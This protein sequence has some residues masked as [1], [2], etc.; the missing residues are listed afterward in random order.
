MNH[1]VSDLL[2][3]ADYQ[4][5]KRRAHVQVEEMMAAAA[6]E[7]RRRGIQIEAA[8][9]ELRRRG[10]QIEDK[11]QHI[12]ELQD[13]I[14]AL[15]KEACDMRQSLRKARAECEKVRTL[16]RCAQCT[17]PSAESTIASVKRKR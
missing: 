8:A 5:D 14:D 2:K 7:L 11:S 13:V 6:Y 4:A 15:R 9:F 3:E 12:H 17:S 16:R 10:A 1:L